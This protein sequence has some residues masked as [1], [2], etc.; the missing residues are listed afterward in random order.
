MSVTYSYYYIGDKK[1]EELD[2]PVLLSVS[3]QKNGKMGEIKPH[4]HSYMEV[5]YFESGNGFFECDGR[6]VEVCAGDCI[7]VGEG[8]RHVQYSADVTPLVYYSFGVTNVFFPEIGKANCISTDSYEHIRAEKCPRVSE[9]VGL[10]NNELESAHANRISAATAY[11]KLLLIYLSRVVNPQV[12]E[13]KEGFSQEVKN[14]LENN[15][16]D[17]ITLNMLCKKF[18]ANKSTLLHAFKRDFG[19]SPLHYL[20]LIRIENAKKLLANGCSVTE[21][22]IKSGFS[23]PVYFAEM[24]KKVNAIT[25]ST[26]KK[27]TQGKIEK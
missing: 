6:K 24:F 27:F 14:Y 13:K 9:F 1:Y 21:S 2:E 11:F 8:K 7:I 4:S 20:N 10:C 17:N 25:P 16:A 15:F 26:F 3:K 22:A 5:F 19:T 18:F 12:E 23:N